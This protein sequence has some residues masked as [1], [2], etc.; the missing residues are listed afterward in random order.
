MEQVYPLLIKWLTPSIVIIGNIFQYS[1]IK[2]IT[3]EKDHWLNVVFVKRGWIWTTLVIILNEIASMRTATNSRRRR[4]RILKQYALMVVWWYIFTQG[5]PM[6]KIFSSDNSNNEGSR[7]FLAPP[8][9]DLIFIMTGGSCSYQVF[10]DDNVQISTLFHGTEI[11]RRKW[12]YLQILQNILL[13]DNRLQRPR[14]SLL[15]SATAAL[16][17]LLHNHNHSHSHSGLPLPAA[18][19]PLSACEAIGHGGG[20]SWNKEIAAVMNEIDGQVASSSARCRQLGGYWSGGHDP[21]GHVFLLTVMVTLLLSE[22]RGG[23]SSR[24]CWQQCVSRAL[25]WLLVVLWCVSLFVTCAVYHTPMEKAAG[26]L[27]G[28]IFAVRAVVT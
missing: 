19:A 4:R 18:S 10:D 7:W 17:C 9:M 8:L 20:N 5:I 28:Y 13:S 25:C 23:G 2:W 3:Q 14:T 24:R 1:N 21:S 26:F 12:K 27:C 6:Y 16:Q 22:L 15:T 11:P